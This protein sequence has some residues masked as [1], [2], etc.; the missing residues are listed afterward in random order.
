[1]VARST[2]VLFHSSVPSKSIDRSITSG[3]RRRRRFGGGRHGIVDL[4]R[5]R[6]ARNRDD[7]NNEEHQHDVDQRRHVDVRIGLALVTAYC[8][9]HL[10]SLLRSRSEMIGRGDERHLADADL[11]GGHEHLPHELIPHVRIAADMHLGLRLFARDAT[12]AAL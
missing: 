3:R 7:E 8:H 5:V 9:R 12:Q 10:G 6:L 4:D 1:M 11:L 2:G